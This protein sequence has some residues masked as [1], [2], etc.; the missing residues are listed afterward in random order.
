MARILAVKNSKLPL[1][2]KYQE[3]LKNFGT[4]LRA[5]RVARRRRIVDIARAAGVSEMTVKSLEAGRGSV[6]LDGL[7]KVL[8]AL[9]EAS[10]LDNL[11]GPD[12]YAPEEE[13]AIARLRPPVR[14]VVVPERVL[15]ESWEDAR[16]AIR[17]IGMRT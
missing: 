1:L 13:E 6:S 12:P 8:G 5:A 11:F 4:R 7:I 10:Q 15:S 16:R 9:G 3:G 17:K 14:R 2:P